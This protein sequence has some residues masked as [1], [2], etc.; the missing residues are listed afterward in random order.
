MFADD[1]D[2]QTSYE[3]CHA[4]S[5]NGGYERLGGRDRLGIVTD[6][7]T[8]SGRPSG[9]R[10][11]DGSRAAFRLAHET[12]EQLQQG[13]GPLVT[14][15][16]ARPGIT[17]NVLIDLVPD[18]GLEPARF[19]QHDLDAVAS[20]L[21]SQGVGR[22]LECVLAGLVPTTEWRGGQPVDGRDVHDAPSTCRAHVG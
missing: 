6:Q 5:D 7:V 15:L 12:H 16:V 18:P 17:G 4:I 22:G 9:E 14:D 3:A 21:E 2:L 8:G 20:D 11:A 13:A 19:D 10:L 1:L